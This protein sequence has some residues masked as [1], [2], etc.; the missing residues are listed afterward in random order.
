MKV[1][2]TLNHPGSIRHLKFMI[3]VKFLGGNL[4]E[5]AELISY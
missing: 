4:A 3:V 2:V 1:T 5:V